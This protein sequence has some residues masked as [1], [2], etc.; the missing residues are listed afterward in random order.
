MLTQKIKQQSTVG[1]SKGRKMS[2]IQK[3]CQS[4]AFPAPW[5]FDFTAAMLSW[6][7]LVLLTLSI[8]R[9]EKIW[10]DTTLLFTPHLQDASIS[11]ISWV[12][13]NAQETW[14]PPNSS[15]GFVGWT[16]FPGV[17]PQPSSISYFAPLL[18]SSPV[19]AAPGFFLLFLYSSSYRCHCQKGWIHRV[20]VSLLWL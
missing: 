13:T 7:V 18:V 17:S 11:T 5:L 1:T 2:L 15:F 10:C 20:P 12:H 9:M 14:R 4:Q 19:T 16:R 8:R 3:H 6:P